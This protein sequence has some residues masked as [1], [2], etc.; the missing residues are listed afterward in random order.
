MVLLKFPAQVFY[1]CIVAA[2]KDSIFQCCIIDI[3][4]C[5]HAGLLETG[6][7]FYFRQFHTFSGIISERLKIRLKIA[8]FFQGLVKRLL[9][10]VKYIFDGTFQFFHAIFEHA[11][12]T[13]L[14]KVVLPVFLV[15][16]LLEYVM[17]NPAYFVWN[18]HFYVFN[19]FVNLVD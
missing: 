14:F 19:G 13:V 7:A 8:L 12:H 1:Q 11:I 2:V 18:V 9:Y 10:S 6:T 5:V 17:H 3:H 4:F 16:M 15:N